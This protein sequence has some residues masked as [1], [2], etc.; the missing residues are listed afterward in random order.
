MSVT[1]VS[2][3]KDTVFEVKE[4]F[5]KKVEVGSFWTVLDPVIS[6]YENYLLVRSS[7]CGKP[8]SITDKNTVGISHDRLAMLI[9]NKA[10]VLGR[11]N[12]LRD[13]ACQWDTE[14]KV[15]DLLKMGIKELYELSEQYCGLDQDKKYTPLELI[16][17]IVDREV[18]IEQART[19]KVRLKHDDWHNIEGKCGA[20]L[21]SSNYLETFF[22]GF[23][24]VN[25]VREDGTN[26]I[27]DAIRVFKNF[28]DGSATPTKIEF[29]PWYE[30]EEVRNVQIPAD[31]KRQIEVLIN[32]EKSCSENLFRVDSLIC[33][34]CGEISTVYVSFGGLVVDELDSGKGL[35]LLQT[36][37]GENGK[38]LF[39][40]I[41]KVNNNLV[42]EDTVITGLDDA[43]ECIEC[44]KMLS[45]QAFLKPIQD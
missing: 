8:R 28:C 38:D 4:L 44:G 23:A 5:S 11:I 3:P 17:I 22:E 7:A 1:F 40:P 45:I 2:Y 30:G 29:V 24:P 36:C 37:A 12:E 20:G 33:P 16:E 13:K 32:N 27:F 43:G 6:H 34:D 15:N 9:K 41:E 25:G 19:D 26:Y 42:I 21:G 39:L 14:N 31:L 10:L 18:E 35:Y